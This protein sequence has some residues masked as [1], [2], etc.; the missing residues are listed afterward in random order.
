MKNTTKFL[1]IIALAAAI[2]FSMTSCG[3][4]SGGGGAR[5][6]GSAFLVSSTDFASVMSNLGRSETVAEL[7]TITPRAAAQQVFD[8][9]RWNGF[10]VVEDDGLTISQIRAFL[11]DEG[12]PSGDRDILVNQLV[13]RGFALGGRVLPSAGLFGIVGALRE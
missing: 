1:G 8:A 9:L 13:S 5:Y 6:M 2:G 7:H 10:S 4:S 11:T 3:G 12:V